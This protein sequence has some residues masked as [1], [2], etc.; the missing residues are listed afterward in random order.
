MASEVNGREVYVIA[1]NPDVYSR[2][3]AVSQLHEVYHDS[4]TSIFHFTDQ[5]LTAHKTKKPVQMMP[6]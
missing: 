4:G 5:N 1:R 6:D 3:A 2:L